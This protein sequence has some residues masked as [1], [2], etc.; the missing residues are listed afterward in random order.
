MLAPNGNIITIGILGKTN[1]LKRSF[2]CHGTCISFILQL[3]VVAL[4]TRTHGCAKL[5]GLEAYLRGTN[6]K[7]QMLKRGGKKYRRINRD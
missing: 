6:A 5:V 1:S 4:T 3:E 2:C 7:Q